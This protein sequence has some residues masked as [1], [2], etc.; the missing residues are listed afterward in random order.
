ML[1]KMKICKIKDCTKKVSAKG[2]CSAHYMRMY[3]NGSYENLQKLRT[4]K[5]IQMHKKGLSSSKIAKTLCMKKNSIIQ[6]LRLHGCLKK[7]PGVETEIKVAEYLKLRNF[8]VKRQRGD[9]YYDLLVD[10]KKVDV[11]S[12]SLNMKGDYIFH[13]QPSRYKNKN[14][15]EIDYFIL[16]CDHWHFRGS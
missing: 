3:N 10:N 2:T 14:H 1:K 16:V 12:S 5:I 13:L 11:K 7:A 15:R 4:D 8:N 9:W 6:L